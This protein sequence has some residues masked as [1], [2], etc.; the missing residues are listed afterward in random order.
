M[1]LWSFASAATATA[2]SSRAKARACWSSAAGRCIQVN[3]Y[4]EAS[5]SSPS[6]SSGILLT[7]AHGDHSRSARDFWPRSIG[8]PIYASLGTLGA[9]HLQDRTLGRPICTGRPYTLGEMDV[10]PFAVPHDC[11]EP[12]GFRFESAPVA[13]ASRPTSAGCRTT[14]PGSSETWT[15]WCSRPTTTRTCSSGTYPHFLKRRVAGTHGHL[16]NAAAAEAIAALRRP[17]PTRGLAGPPERA[18][19]LRPSTRCTTVGRVLKRYGLGHVPTDAR[20]ATAAR[21]C[22]GPAASL[23]DAS[24][25]SSPDALR[26]TSALASSTTSVPP[27]FERRDP[28][29]VRRLLARRGGSHLAAVVEPDPVQRSDR[30]ADHGR[31]AAVRAVLARS[32]AAAASRATCRSRSA[33]APLTSTRSAT[34]AT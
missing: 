24:C 34:A 16:S 10:L 28:R 27:T 25:R 33:S 8:V 22:T 9:S 1:Q 6:R 5:A 3:D 18:E 19:Q 15:C 32:G 26:A 11:R 17:R 21:T 29:R 12:L 20:R 30:A 31:H 2:T 13:P 7:H 14:S 23:R 4:L